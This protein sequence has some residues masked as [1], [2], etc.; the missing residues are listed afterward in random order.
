MSDR[1]RQVIAGENLYQATYNMSATGTA[2][3][4]RLVV[5]KDAGE[6]EREIENCSEIKL[7]EKDI[8]MSV[9]INED[10]VQSVEDK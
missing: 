4:C 1:R 6:V 3:Y 10:Q 7:I 8:S 9:P 2:E 5:A